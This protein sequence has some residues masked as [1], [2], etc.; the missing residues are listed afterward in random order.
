MYRPLLYLAIV[1]DSRDHLT[2]S[3]FFIPRSFHTTQDDHEK[4][5]VV[6]I[7]N[8]AVMS[9]A[10]AIALAT[11]F[12]DRASATGCHPAYFS[13]RTY[14]IG[15]WASASVTTAAPCFIPCSPPGVGDCPASGLKME[16]SCI[17]EISEMYNFQCISDNCSNEFVFGGWID[18]DSAWKMESAPCS[19]VRQMRN[20]V[21]ISHALF[22][23]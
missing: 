21:L 6:I 5:M 22:A 8:F 13:G 15:E 3:I 19:L 23:S 16:G 12:V 10:I 7:N 4:V 17:R 9:R 2:I 11:S 14:A 1:T 20:E 18:S